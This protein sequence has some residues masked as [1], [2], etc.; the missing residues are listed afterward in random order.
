MEVIDKYG[1]R[2]RRDG[3]L[4]DGDR[5]TVPMRMMDVA[6]P[7]LA[8]AAALADAVK[9]NEQFDGRQH[10]PGF[11]GTTQDVYAAG[12]A[13][14]EARDASIRDAWRN[15]PPVIDTAKPSE[16]AALVP[17]TAPNAQLFAARDQAIADRDR[18]VQAAWKP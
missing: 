7:G 18:R 8:A 12:D 14:R 13:A 15:P 9:R 4:Q 3:V 6:N 5:M 2:V 17:V 16:P 11:A 10:R 1:K